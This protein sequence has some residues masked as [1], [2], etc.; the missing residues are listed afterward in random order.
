MHQACD[1][2]QNMILA[3]SHMHSNFSTDSKSDP[4]EMIE[5]AI[6]RGLKIMT[7]TD[8]MDVEWP[9]DNTEFIFDP[10]QYFETWNALKD[11]YK[12]RLDIR[13]GMEYGLR[14][15]ENVLEIVD[16]KWDELRKLPFDFIIGSTHVCDNSDPY[17]DVFWEGKSANERILDYYNSVLFNVE[18]YSGFDVYGHLD[19]IARYVPEGNHYEVT[20]YMDVYEQVLRI[21][22][23]RG[24]GL[25]IN[26]SLLNKGFSKPNP[27]PVV[28]KMYKEMGGEIIT[29]GSDAHRTDFIGGNFD[30]AAEILKGAGFKYY[31]V[32]KDHKPEF[33]EI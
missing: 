5:T 30:K 9:L 31:T 19:Y 27:D 32:F 21:L 33:F 24:I 17:Y 18:H 20:R 12:D 14:D 2:V 23:D 16:K 4:R 6:K 3:D 26:T 28:L 13:I 29:C 25:E 10:K 7:I 15:E 1:M 8:H 11:E 22:I